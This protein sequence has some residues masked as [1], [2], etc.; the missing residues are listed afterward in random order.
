MPIIPGTEITGETEK[1]PGLVHL[2]NKEERAAYYEQ[3][4][5]EQRGRA[6]ERTK[7]EAEEKIEL[8]S[9]V[10]QRGASKDI[11]KKGAVHA[12]EVIFDNFVKVRG[13]IPSDVRNRAIDEGCEN[14]IKYLKQKATADRILK[15]VE[16]EM[17]DTLPENFRG[18]TQWGE[19]VA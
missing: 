3:Q 10:M 5:Q 4:V 8:L 18:E 19:R 17:V 13:N 11:V 16:K 9:Q 7:K 15:M 2:G 14:I 6:T 12:A 1:V